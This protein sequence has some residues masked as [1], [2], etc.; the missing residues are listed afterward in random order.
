MIR[1]LARRMKL[2]DHIAET[3]YGT[4]LVTAVL[5][6]VSETDYGAAQIDIAVL[7]TACVF[8]LTHAWAFGMEHSAA[9]GRSFGRRSFAG[10]IA[11]EW[12]MVRAALPTVLIMLLAVFDVTSVADAVTIAIT[13]NQG[14][15]F[16][17]GYHLERDVGGGRMRGFL[18]GLMCLMLG[19]ILVALKISID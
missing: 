9:A 17:W 19:L 8:A 15:L 3:L 7:V 1:S 12:Y 16:F 14:L 18:A 11:D 10:S 13:L 4:V 5:A 2:R 6:S